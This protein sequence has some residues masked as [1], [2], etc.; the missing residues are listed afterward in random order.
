VGNLVGNLVPKTASCG[1]LGG[2]W[3]PKR[4]RV[5][6]LGGNINPQNGA[7]LGF[8]GESGPQNGAGVLGFW[9]ESGP[10]TASFL[11]TCMSEASSTRRPLFCLFE[12]ETNCNCLKL[13]LKLSDSLSSPSL[14]GFL[15]QTFPRTKYTPIKHSN[16]PN[17]THSLA[18]VDTTAQ[19]SK[20]Q[21]S[22]EKGEL[23]FP[24]SSVIFNFFV[25]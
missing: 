13:K 3:S 9:G 14:H 16:F 21:S 19:G 6:L 15:L 4:C 5:G 8:W 2:K 24:F 1:L 12:T 23:T 22:K 17:V 10:Q 18:P 11:Q 20:K 25:S 7:V